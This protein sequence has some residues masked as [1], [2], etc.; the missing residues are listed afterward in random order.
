VE[1]GPSLGARKN[2]PI[3]GFA[4][5]TTCPRSGTTAGSGT[6]SRAPIPVQFAMSGASSERS[7]VTGAPMS[8]MPPAALKRS[9]R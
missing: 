7:D 1:S 3:P 9:T 5:I 2:S 4:T 6:R 8:R